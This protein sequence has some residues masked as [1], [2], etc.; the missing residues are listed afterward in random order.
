MYPCNALFSSVPGVQ[1]GEV[2]SSFELRLNLLTISRS[3]CAVALMPRPCRRPPL[4]HTASKVQYTRFSGCKLPWTVGKPSPPRASAPCVGCQRVGSDQSARTLADPATAEAFAYRQYDKGDNGDNGRF[5]HSPCA[6]GRWR[7]G[8][9]RPHLFRRSR[10]GPSKGPAR[11]G[12][13]G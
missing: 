11:C 8:S 4:P 9:M 10:P 1:A 3:T 13:P 12:I 6:R 5:R 2:D 7:S